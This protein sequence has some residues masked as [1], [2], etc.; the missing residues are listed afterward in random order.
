M[1]GLSVGQDVIVRYGQGAKG[2][3]ATEVRPA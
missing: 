2:L 3:M 1:A